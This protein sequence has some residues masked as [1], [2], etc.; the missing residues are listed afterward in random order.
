MQ[1][2]SRVRVLMFLTL[3]GVVFSGSVLFAGDDVKLNNSTIAPAA[4]GVLN[5]ST[6]RNGNTNVE[7]KVEH[8]AKP[9]ALSPAKSRYVVWVQTRGGSPANV[10][11][12]QV[13]DDL[14]GSL[15]STTP[16]ASFDVIVTAEDSEMA[17]QASSMEVLR[18]TVQ[19]P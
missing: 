14:R 5:Y 2:K 9:Q 10:G 1:R 7:V 19:K 6:D 3:V 18:G 8:L 4:R 12:L 15:K 13:N 17:T 11:N 16:N